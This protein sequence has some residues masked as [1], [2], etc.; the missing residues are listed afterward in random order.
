MITNTRILRFKNKEIERINDKIQ[1]NELITKEEQDKI[2]NYFLNN[3]PKDEIKKGGSKE[4][5][6]LK[7]N[8]K[9]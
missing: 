7:I 9:E 8:K 1:K 3:S 5:L 4:N 2:F 6:N